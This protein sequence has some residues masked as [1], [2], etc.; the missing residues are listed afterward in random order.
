MKF[1]LSLS[2]IP[3]LLLTNVSAAE[4]LSLPTYGEES[5]TL[6]KY[7]NPTVKG[8]PL[9]ALL[10]GEPD[11]GWWDSLNIEIIK[12]RADDLCILLG[13]NKTGIV[14]L[15]EDIQ[16]R[17]EGK[18]YLDGEIVDIKAEYWDFWTDDNE[19]SGIFKVLRCID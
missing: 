1:L 7:Q 3:L 19:T 12:K 4:E 2:L 9:L 6:H 18:A 13:H 17:F 11:S 16:Y 10:E 14:L 8:A 15:E 5:S